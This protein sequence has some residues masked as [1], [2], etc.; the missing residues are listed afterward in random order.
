MVRQAVMVAGTE[1]G[2]LTCGQAR[3]SLSETKERQL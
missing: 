1:A 3:E 2:C